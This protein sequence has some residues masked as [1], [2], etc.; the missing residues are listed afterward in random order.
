[1]DLPDKKGQLVISHRMPETVK[2]DSI[3][4]QA[5]ELAI[6][7]LLNNIRGTIKVEAAK[8]PCGHP[9][10]QPWEQDK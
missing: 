8:R 2:F 7:A 5:H 9:G 3:Q 1:M 6:W 10:L 4:K